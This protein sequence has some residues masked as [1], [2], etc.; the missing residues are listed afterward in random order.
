MRDWHTACT[1]TTILFSPW[2]CLNFAVLLKTPPKTMIPYNR[3]IFPIFN[4]YFKSPLSIYKS[5]LRVFIKKKPSTRANCSKKIIRVNLVAKMYFP[6]L[7][8]WT[9][10]GFSRKW[11]GP[12]FSRNWKWKNYCIKSSR[13]G[14]SWLS[15]I[16]MKQNWLNIST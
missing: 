5:K 12:T 14:F 4:S 7:L 16:M 2:S 1:S 8:F 10:S 15:I 3:L 11:L 13:L 9:C 6:M